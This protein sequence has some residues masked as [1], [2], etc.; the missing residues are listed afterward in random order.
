MLAAWPF[1][2]V[3]RSVLSYPFDVVTPLPTDRE[4]LNEPFRASA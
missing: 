3:P 4:A 1:R 2:S